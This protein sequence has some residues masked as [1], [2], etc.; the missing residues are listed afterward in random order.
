[1][2]PGSLSY[3]T[4]S[5]EPATIGAGAIF[6][7]ITV[8]A[9]DQYSNQKTDYT[10]TVEFST[11][12]PN[13]FGNVRLNGSVPGPG[14]QYTFLPGDSGSHLFAT[15]FILET[16]GNQTI[17]VND[18]VQTTVIETTGVINVT[19]G[20][21][22]SFTLDDPGTVTAGV[23][24]TLSVSSVQ[25]AFGNAADGTIDITWVGGD[26]GTPA[27]PDGT[28]PSFAQIIVTGGS[29]S[30][31]QT[32]TKADT[33]VVLRG[34]DPVSLNFDDTDGV[35]AFTVQPGALDY[36]TV[37]SGAGGNIANQ[38][39]GVAFPIDITAVDVYGNQLDSGLNQY[40][41]SVDLSLSNGE[42]I[43]T[44]SGAFTI[45]FLDDF[46]VTI[47]TADTG[48]RIQI[49]DSGGTYGTDPSGL[50]NAFSIQPGVADHFDIVTDPIADQTAGIGFT[51][52]I[53]AQDA[54]NNILS[55]G[56]NKYNENEAVLSD[57]GPD[58]L[59][60]VPSTLKFANGVWETAVTI[61]GANIGANQTQLQ[62]I[63]NV[64]GV[65]LTSDTSN[66]FTVNP[67]ALDH[68]TFTTNPNNLEP[69][70]SPIAIVI[71]ARDAYENLVTSY[72]GTATI[73]DSTAT[74]YE[75]PTPGDS[76]I[77]FA[78]GQYNGS[79]V[80]TQTQQDIV[81]TVRD[82]VIVGKST[83]FSA[84]GNEFA[85]T[86]GTTT[87]PKIALTGDTIEMFDFIINNSHPTDDLVLNS[88]D[89]Y[90][91]C[92]SSAEFSVVNPSVLIDSMSIEDIT[93]TGTYVNAPLPNT[94]SAVTV[95]LTGITVPAGDNNV[96]LRVSVKIRSDISGAPIPSIQLRVKSIDTDRLGVQGNAV[97]NYTDLT[98]IS[99]P[100]AYI[101]SSVTNIKTSQGDAAY[102]YPNPF[103]PRSQTT[104]I[105]FYNPAGNT[106]VSVKIFTLTGKLVKSITQ[107]VSGE[108]SRYVDWNGRNG[109]GQVVRNGVYV[110]VIQLG[111]TRIMVKIA[112]VK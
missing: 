23:S 30:A 107:S 14:T 45:G 81:I 4:I 101:Q 104:R 25:D 10:G 6:S 84:I 91:A 55:F 39:A 110:A 103:N 49:V 57:V 59:T 21:I 89:I 111:S 99:D 65:Q 44:P 35:D 53:E 68:F 90:V 37:K 24:F 9:Y 11:T 42:T 109:K 38:T 95:P 52:R 61:T 82:G 80:I 78:V 93:N 85:V 32:L 27:A 79:V 48:V 67:G 41:G 72:A 60:V 29:G 28:Q 56:T 64:G 63:D 17:S 3:Y 26:S 86:L 50:S 19:S 108:G 36:F 102:N 5:G 40:S 83:P 54:N 71:E 43:T 34:T 98:P 106:S 70:N 8:T 112:V 77:T 100:E 62:V 97:N 66:L 18:T 22:A 20:V 69:T 105:V 7:N 13:T 92:S 16:P 87:A 73:S 31:T 76:A 75:S 1:M 47:N 33:N 51:V 58:S 2:N 94:A 96:T 15:N 88:I 74:V 46:N 12:D